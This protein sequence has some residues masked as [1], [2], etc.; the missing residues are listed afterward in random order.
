MSKRVMG[1]AV[2]M[3]KDLNAL[4]LQLLEAIDIK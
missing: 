1:S 4:G 3:A 2:A